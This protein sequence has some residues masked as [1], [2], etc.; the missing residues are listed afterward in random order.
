M[1][2]V[3]GHLGP[4]V[5]KFADSIRLSGGEVA[6]FG[7]ISADV[8]EFPAGGSV[9]GCDRDSLPISGTYG[10]VAFMEPPQRL[11]GIG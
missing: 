5:G 9:W 3:R 10:A 7:P 11:M 4:K 6:G 2:E 8:I 1:G